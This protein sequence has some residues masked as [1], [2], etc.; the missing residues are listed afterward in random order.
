MSTTNRALAAVS[1]VIAALTLSAAGRGQDAGEAYITVLGGG[2][3]ERLTA[4]GAAPIDPTRFSL[5]RNQLNASDG[6]RT[7]A[8][9]TA[10]V[11]LPGLDALVYLEPATELRLGTPPAADSGVALIIGV[12]S[13]RAT[14]VQKATSQHW[15]AIEAGS[16]SGGPAAYTLS[17]GAA[18]FIE[19][20]PD[21]VSFASRRG[22]GS[23][24]KGLVPAAKLIDASGALA[25]ASSVTVAEGKRMTVRAAAQ[26]AAENDA[27]A[28]VPTG[29]GDT[30]RTFATNQSA[31]WLE[32]AERG[33]FTPVRGAARGAPELLS[34]G[35][36]PA[37]VFDQP[38]PALTTATA[39]PADTAVRPTLDPS[40]ALTQ[41]GTPGSAVAGQ[42]F[43]RSRI[44]ANPGTSRTGALQINQFSTP[45]FQLA[46]GQ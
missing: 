36:E 43:R 13:G 14:V 29:L 23:L 7:V 24:Y 34:A 40:Q 11:V 8:D 22:Q 33:D 31:R 25:G 28:V 3:A 30:V 26:P 39:R 46:G 16:K 6:L 10:V 1:A 18:L 5:D 35:F 15:L 4:E 17:K 41:A 19:S 42:K 20:G 27:G 32:A 45:V 37:M 21:G 44:I 9:G 2:G 12:V 38:R